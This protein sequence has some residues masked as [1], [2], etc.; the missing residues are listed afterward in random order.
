MQRKSIETDAQHKTTKKIKDVVDDERYWIRIKT[1]P[2][3][4]SELRIF[5]NIEQGN[6]T[7]KEQM[8]F[9]LYARMGITGSQ[10]ST[11]LGFGPGSVKTFIETCCG[12][13]TKAKERE[14]S[15]IIDKFGPY[16]LDTIV[17]IAPTI[18]PSEFVK[19]R[20]YQTSNDGARYMLHGKKH[21]PVAATLF[22]V[23]T[24]YYSIPV[25]IIIN[26]KLPQ[27]KVSCDPVILFPE[28]V[29]ISEQRETRT[30]NGELN[31]EYYYAGVRINRPKTRT[32]TEIKCTKALMEGLTAQYYWQMQAEMFVTRSRAGY[33]VNLV[34]SED[35]E[36]RDKYG[37]VLR[38]FYVEFD[39]KAWETIAQPRII[40][41]ANAI[42]E[43]DF[44]YQPTFPQKSF[45]VHML[46]YEDYEISEELYQKA[47]DFDMGDPAN[48]YENVF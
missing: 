21:E 7:S 34:V 9:W 4:K 3:S 23:K 22:F 47:L 31:I 11:V 8:E 45:Q 33:L 16:N 36:T 15:K 27:L 26:N 32:I 30:K 2:Y 6:S 38:V 14:V 10:C 28:Y 44:D 46:A 41:V 17:R 25:G 12:R 20:D 48:T 24:G 19:P 40:E 35:K 37:I 13:L 43:R 5:A 1:T 39:D 18:P 42:N 29:T